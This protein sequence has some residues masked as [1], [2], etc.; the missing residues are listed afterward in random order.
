[1]FLLLL[2]S[3]R[4]KCLKSKVAEINDKKCMK[5]EKPIK[6]EKSF[7]TDKWEKGMK[8]REKQLGIK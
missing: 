4:A 5:K 3:I 7:L 2:L 1:M 8:T 6:E